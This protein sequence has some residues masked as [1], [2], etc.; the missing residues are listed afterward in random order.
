MP[1][2]IVIGT[3]WGDE[4]KG[5]IVDL[6]AAKADVVARFNGGDNAGHTVTVGSRTFKLHLIPSGIIHPHTIG[7]MG[8]GMVIN[9]VTFVNEVE[10]LQAA[11]VAANPERLRI[12]HAAHLI[13]PAHRALDAAQEAAR[14][15][16]QIGT[17]GRGI[18]PAYTGKTS[19]NGLRMEDMLDASSFYKKM[20]QHVEEINTMLVKL[21][22]ADP[23]DENAVAREYAKLALQ[24]APYITDTGELVY[25]ALQQGKRVLAEGAQGTLLDLDH[26]TYP[27]VTSSYATAAGA[28]VGLGVGIVPVERVIGVTKSFQTR[29]GAG[30]F[31]TEVFGKTAERLRGTG[32]NPWDEF[33]T[34]TGRP[35]RVGW[36]D[37]VLLRYAL[38]VNGVTELM[39]TKMDILSGLTNLRLCTAYQQ[40]SQM[41]RELP[42]GPA[43]LT[44]YEPVYEELAGWEEEITSVRRWQELPEAARAYAQRL[45]EFCGV[46]VRRLSVGPEREQVVDVPL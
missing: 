13:T 5:R 15:Q 7:V 23:L 38:R 34:T 39:V 28:L 12:S 31:P 40:G 29:V 8:N 4:G 46:P 10:M 2:E 42:L 44:P 27:Y 45:S 14:G 1:L 25:R 37:G 36:L 43:N 9:P 11:G 6:L 35:R 17:T 18:G 33:G 41:V 19:R 21:Y 30:P 26:G 32:K 20:K 3:Q 24:L 16:A 22:R